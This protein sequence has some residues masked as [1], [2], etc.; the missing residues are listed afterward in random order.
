MNAI[1]GEG[2][3]KKA[4][5]WTSEKVTVLGDAVWNHGPDDLKGAN[6]THAMVSQ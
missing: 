5:P 4:T 1:S 3:Y 6:L 2:E